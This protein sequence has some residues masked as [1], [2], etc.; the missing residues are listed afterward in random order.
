[1]TWVRTETYESP[2]RGLKY[3]HGNRLWLGIDRWEL[4]SKVI[5]GKRWNFVCIISAIQTSFWE[6]FG[7]DFSPVGGSKW[8][9]CIYNVRAYYIVWDQLKFYFFSFLSK[10][11]CVWPKSTPF[12]PSLLFVCFLNGLEICKQTTLWWIWITNNRRKSTTW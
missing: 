2:N 3:F 6:T 4:T 10:T 8:N 1:M 11:S 7:F 9:F 12:I 5:V